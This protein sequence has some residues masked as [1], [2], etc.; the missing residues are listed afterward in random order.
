MKTADK[1]NTR[2][3]FL[4]IMNYQPVDR[5]PVIYW[6][7]WEETR[8]RWLKEGLPAGLK[9]DELRAFLRAD[10]FWWYVSGGPVTPGAMKLLPAFPEETVEETDQFRIVRNAAG[11]VTKTFKNQSSIPHSLDHTFKTARD[12]PEYKKR[13]QPDPRR[14][15]QDID[16]RVRI[17]Q[18]LGVPLCLPVGSLMGWLRDWMGVENMC[19]LIYDDPDC[20]ADIVNTIAELSC[21]A[22]DQIVPRMAVKPDLCFIWEDICGSTGPFVSPHIFRQFVA[23]GY[24]KIRHKMDE[25]GIP[26]LCVDSDG[27]TDALI[28]PWMEGGVNLLFPVEPGVWQGTP[29]KIR[30]KYGR[31]LRLIGGFN[32]LVLEKDR[33]AIDAEIKAHIPLMKEGGYLM[34]PDHVITP[35]TSLANYRYYLDSIRTLRF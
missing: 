19:Y 21:W 16:E 12:W 22:M 1:M 25:L 8:T 15:P 29:E 28:R 20:Y 18:Q 3:L 35:G 26:I 23:P 13:L 17:G 32:K 9:D 34:M 7:M 2:D 6:G 27:N 31:D 30:K 11:I 10:L 5:M 33:A 24:I 4:A 14:I